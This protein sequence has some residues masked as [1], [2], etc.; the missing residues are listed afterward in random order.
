M[1]RWQY[2]KGLIFFRPIFRLTKLAFLRARPTLKKN[3]TTAPE[4]NKSALCRIASLSFSFVRDPERKNQSVLFTRWVG[5]YVEGFFCRCC[6]CTGAWRNK[7]DSGPRWFSDSLFGQWLYH[8]FLELYSVSILFKS[9]RF[10][11][12]DYLKKK[13]LNLDNTVEPLGTDTSL[14]RTPLYYGQFSMSR[15]NSHI[16]SLKNPSTIQSLSNTDNGH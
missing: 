7:R 16:F 12:L 13:A 4:I 1:Q 9:L 3:T 2:G 5:L 8:F 15:Q 10:C 11:L 6:F 14:R